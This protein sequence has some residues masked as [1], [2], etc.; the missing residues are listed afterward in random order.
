MH[1]RWESGFEIS[2]SVREGEVT[3]AANKEGLLS[4]ANILTDLANESVDGHVHL[5]EHNSLEEGS[6][7][8]VIERVSK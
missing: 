3:I 6:V 8:L 1:I 4:L 7:E 2:T 5:D